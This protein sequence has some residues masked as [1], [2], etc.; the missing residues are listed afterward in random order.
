MNTLFENIIGFHKRHRTL[1]HILFWAFILLSGSIKQLLD[2][3]T[4]LF[5]LLDRL[6]V[7]FLDNFAKIPTAYFV[8]Y[9]LFPR[10]YEQKKYFSSL[11]LFVL[12]GYLIYIISSIIRILVFPYLGI[13]IAEANPLVSLFTNPNGFYQFF[14][15][16]N[17]GGGATMLLI[18]MILNHTEVQRKALIVDKLKAEIE[19]KSLKIQLN[20]H[21]LFNTLNN[22][23]SLSVQNSPKTSDSIARLSEILDYIL[24]RCNSQKVPIKGEVLLLENYISLEKLRYDARLKVIFEKNIQ[25][26]VEIAPLLLLTLVENA[27]K[28]G[29]GEDSG[30]PEIKMNLTANKNLIEFMI[31]NHISGQ[32]IA[33]THTKGIGLN[34][35]KQQLDL[36]YGKNYWIEFKQKDNTFKVFLKINLKSE[37]I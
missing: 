33:E 14:F 10:F 18:K 8:V 20:P 13:S 15:F 26:E 7:D 21:F 11:I 17:L 27:F 34:N 25:Y 12:G 6:V 32:Q 22:I 23:Y 30:S 5:S 37:T 36:I 2:N 3:D 9:Y 4:G 29:A 24:Y 35:L 16:K 19:L 28:H 31:E 1:T